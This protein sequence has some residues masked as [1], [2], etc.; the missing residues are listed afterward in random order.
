M[1]I[2]VDPSMA[3]HLASFVMTPSIA[4]SMNLS[5]VQMSEFGWTHQ[6]KYHQQSWHIFLPLILPSIL[7]R[8]LHQ[9]PLP[10][11]GVPVLTSFFQLKNLLNVKDVVKF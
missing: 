7:L 10:G 2:F 3:A 11:P 4:E 6:R 9:T 5:I 1:F 8:V